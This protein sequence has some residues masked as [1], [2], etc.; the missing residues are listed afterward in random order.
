MTSTRRWA[1]WPATGLV[2]GA[3]AALFFLDPVRHG[4]IP[5]CLFHRLTGWNCPGCGA[6]RALYALLHGDVIAALH[7][8]AL[9]VG[10]LPSLAW[11]AIR[12]VFRRRQGQRMAEAIRPAWFWSF[13]G[14]MAVFTVLRNLPAFTWLAPQ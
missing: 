13:F 5:P 10:A 9:A 4:F 3:A 14:V 6:T 2:A 8:N 7:D 12:N 1:N 11:M